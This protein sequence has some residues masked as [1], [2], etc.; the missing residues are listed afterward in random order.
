MQSETNIVWNGKAARLCFLRIIINKKRV[1][2][3]FS[4]R[5]LTIFMSVN[6]LDNQCETPVP[7]NLITP[8]FSLY[9]VTPDM[10][11]VF[12]FSML[13]AT[14]TISSQSQVLYYVI[15]YGKV[16]FGLQRFSIL[17]KWEMSKSLN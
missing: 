4:V 6:H 2:G 7:T 16:I 11:R 9:V 10:V 17:D 12:G 1:T 15:K 14:C 3:A 5:G 8:T 13:T